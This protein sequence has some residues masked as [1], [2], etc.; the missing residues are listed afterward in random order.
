MLGTKENGKMATKKNFLQKTNTKY[1][2]SPAWFSKEKG[3]EKKNAQKMC[4]KLGPEV[5]S[6]K[7]ARKDTKNRLNGR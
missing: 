7:V 3:K 5:F 4:K 6:P 2:F 1:N